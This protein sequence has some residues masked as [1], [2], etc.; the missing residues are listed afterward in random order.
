MNN[1]NNTNNKV[2]IVAFSIL[3]IYIIYYNSCKKEKLI[4]VY[5]EKVKKECSEKSLNYSIFGY[6]V[7]KLNNH[8]YVN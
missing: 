7:N 2:I 5:N 4:N 3:A 6:T 1:M 8:R